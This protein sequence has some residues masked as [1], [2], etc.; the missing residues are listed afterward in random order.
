MGTRAGDWWLSTKSISFTVLL[1]YIVAATSAET[2]L[3]TELGR[4][5][6]AYSALGDFAACSST[7]KR[8]LLRS[9]F[10]EHWWLSA[11]VSPTPE[12]SRDHRAE[13]RPAPVRVLH[14]M[15][16]NF[17]MT[18]VETFI[19]QLSAAQKRAGL[20]P[21][22]AM[23]LDNREEVRAIALDLGIEVHDLP[24]RGS[25]V[26]KLPRKLGTALLRVRRIQA[27]VRIL[28][29]SD[30]MH[31]Q[32]VGISCL[33]GFVAARLARTEA[34]IVTH[35]GTLSWF[36]TQR[37]LLSDATFWIEKRWASH[38]VMPYASAAA[39]L[40]AEGMPEHRTS[41]IPFCVDEKLF[42]GLASLPAPGELTL[43]MA[44]RMY[45]GKGQVHLLAALAK[46]LPRYPNVRALLI[47]DGP[48]RPE[49]EAKIDHL[50]L[51]HVVTSM[52]RVDHREIPALMRTAHVVV[53]PSCMVG[54]MFPLCLIE[55]MALGLPAIA[56]RFSGIPDIVEDGE[57]G[58]LV[59]PRDE[60]ALARAIERF[61][62]EPAFYARSRQNA[63]ARFRSRYAATAVARAYS[64]QYEAALPDKGTA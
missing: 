41:V 38:V 43:V 64:E 25:I 10:E 18:G 54:E 42:S 56:T 35:H 51:R 36:A 63:L 53:L 61:L 2:L 50:G 37:N 32:A 23:D 52:G 39:E 40:V 9:P 20:M 24:T 46:L 59:E 60:D 33:D 29:D 55:G 44:A 15:G 19:L 21:S 3:W 30:V 48:T 45:Y 31:I 5:L 7:C 12:Q 26:N 28:Q 22:I 49:V 6:V 1:V 27:L 57:T 16:T 11:I 62:E 14:Y 8:S 4:L 34:L 13:H 17:G 47:G 58:I